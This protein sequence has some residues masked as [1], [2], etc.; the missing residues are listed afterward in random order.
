MSIP[1]IVYLT[2]S[3]YGHSRKV[4]R[5]TG[6]FKPSF[7]QISHILW[8]AQLRG[9][10]FP[11]T[12]FKRVLIGRGVSPGHNF[13]LRPSFGNGFTMYLIKGVRFHFFRIIFVIRFV[14]GLLD[15]N[16]GLATGIYCPILA[17]SQY[18]IAITP[19]DA[20]RFRARRAW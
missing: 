2:P 13:N 1:F 7:Y 20:C 5:L 9:E 10:Q 15:C 12:A 8:L 19:K 14:Q 18:I 11:H 16:F 17:N 3:Q 6:Y 4:Q